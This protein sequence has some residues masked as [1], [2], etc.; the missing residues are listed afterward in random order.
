[1]VLLVKDIVWVWVISKGYRGQE[2]GCCEQLG[3]LAAS[4]YIESLK[5]G[6]FQRF[7]ITACHPNLLRLIHKCI[8]SKLSFIFIYNRY[9]YNDLNLANIPV[10]CLP[11]AS[12]ILV[13][14]RCLSIYLKIVTIIK[15][16]D[17]RLLHNGI[18]ISKSERRRKLFRFNLVT[19]YHFT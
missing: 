4:D 12:R 16:N 19:S 17:C 13:P 1:M 14:S 18:S 5:L 6:D 8:S 15:R 11:A 7:N 9:L 10:K 3:K 2:R